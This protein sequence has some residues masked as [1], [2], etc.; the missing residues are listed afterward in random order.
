MLIF[1]EYSASFP[2]LITFFFYL[3]TLVSH[4]YEKKMPNFEPRPEDL[5]VEKG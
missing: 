2:V 1:S 5:G 4:D 3:E